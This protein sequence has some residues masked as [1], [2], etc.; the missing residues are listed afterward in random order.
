MTYAE[1]ASKAHQAYRAAIQKARAFTDPDL[2]PEAIQKRQAEMQ[3]A[4]EDQRARDLRTI[5]AGAR[6]SYA[7]ANAAA[8]EQRPKIIDHAQV[9]A[10]WAQY[11]PLL[12]SGRPV[13][14]VLAKADVAGVQAIQDYGPSY[15]QAKVG[16]PGLG[17]EPTTVPDIARLCDDRYIALGGDA[18]RYITREREAQADMEKALVYT[19][20]SSADSDLALAIKAHY[21]GTDP[22]DD[23]E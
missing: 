5:E 7:T 16:L 12:D 21:T 2:N 15:F 17:Q 18:A 23:E 3:R 11:K 8:G 4:A 14:Q 9:A 10:R 13:R 19:Q 6:D 22:A 20:A 1:Q